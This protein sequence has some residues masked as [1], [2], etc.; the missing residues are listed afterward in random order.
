MRT[1]TQTIVFSD[2][3]T[4]ESTNLSVANSVGFL[5]ATLQK[6]WGE[7]KQSQLME[8]LTQNGGGEYKEVWLEHVEQVRKDFLSGNSSFLMLSSSMTPEKC[9]LKTAAIQMTRALTILV[10]NPMDEAGCGDLRSALER[11]DGLCMQAAVSD[12]NDASMQ[13][14]CFEIMCAGFLAL[15]EPQA[16]IASIRSQMQLLFEHEEIRLA[17]KTLSLTMGGLANGSSGS[18]RKV[19]YREQKALLDLFFSRICAAVAICERMYG[20]RERYHRSRFECMFLQGLHHEE[21]VEF[22]WLIESNWEELRVFKMAFHE[23]VAV[24]AVPGIALAVADP[25]IG[26]MAAVGSAPLLMKHVPFLTKPLMVFDQNDAN[27]Y[28]MRNIIMRIGQ[29]QPIHTKNIIED[30][31]VIPEVEEEEKEMEQG[32]AISFDTTTSV[33]IHNDE[34]QEE[35]KM[36]EGN[37]TLKNSYASDSAVTTTENQDPHQEPQSILSTVHDEE[38]QEKGDGI[39]ESSCASA[40][41]VTAI[42]NQDRRYIASSIHNDEKTSIGV[43]QDEVG[44]EKSPKEEIREQEDDLEYEWLKVDNYP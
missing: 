3:W 4:I 27:L 16:A 42:E 14:M 17:M 10:E 36:D 22:P 44:N 38:T 34:T 35:K 7:S 15:R 29:G 31:E 39:H 40:S 1:G 24:A 20:E 11:V 30:Q 19:L 37:E 9:E 32:D 23:T 8:R 13:I 43:H 28:D 18:T 5:V 41:F 26:V 12:Q 25:F 21:L 6:Y 2:D 33:T